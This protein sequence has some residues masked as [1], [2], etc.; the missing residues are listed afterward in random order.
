MPVTGP[1]IVISNHLHIIDPPIVVAGT[2]RKLVVMAKRELFE[3]FFAGG[4]FRAMGTFP[5]DRFG[6]DIGALR[7]ARKVLR[8]GGA[9]LMFPEGT[10]SR[11]GGLRPALPG[12]AMVALMSGAPIVPCAIT[13]SES[14][15]LPHVLWGWVRGSRPRIQLAVG[16]PFTLPEELKADSRGAEQAIDYMMRRIADLLPE[17]YR[18][19]YGRQSAGRIVFAR[20]EAATPT[21]ED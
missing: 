4:Y 15:R 13:G 19:A 6:A 3:V 1:V 9:L 21:A 17:S 10:R 2:R 12:A 18:G 16:E 7:T 14:V 5:V 20:H 8:E 11:G